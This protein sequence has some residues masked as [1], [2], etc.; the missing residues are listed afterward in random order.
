MAEF[1]EERDHI[2]VLQPGH[3]LARLRVDE[4]ADEGRLWKLDPSDPRSNAEARG[5]AELPFPG[6][7]VEEEPP[8]RLS[9]FSDLVTFDGRVPELI[10]MV[11][12]ELEIEQFAAESEESVTDRP[13]R[14]VRAECA[15]IDPVL[16]RLDLVSEE[17][18]IPRIQLRR[19]GLVALL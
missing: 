8:D 9:P 13:I 6:N 17:G 15:G 19:V 14:Q 3:L 7:H 1:V 16:F 18:L 2:L 10:R 5:V 11:R 12:V 4:I